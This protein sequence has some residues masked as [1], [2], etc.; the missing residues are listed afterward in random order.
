M[1]LEIKNAILGYRN[2]V[3]LQD[4]NIYLETGRTTC[5]IG[6]NGAGKTTLFKSILGVLPLLDGEILFDGKNIRTWKRRRL[7]RVVAYVPQVRSLSFAY[8]VF[9]VVLFGRTA[10]LS[11]F[12]SPAKKDRMIAEECLEKL[13]ISHLK[14]RIFT[15]LSG[16]EQ[17]MVIIARALAQKTSFLVMDE[18]T[19]GLDFGNQIQIINRVN[20]LKN[21][22]LGI[23]MATHSPDH[24]FMCNADVAIVHKN[25]IWRQGHC[26]RIIT[27]DVL[28]EIY[29]ISVK[30]HSVADRQPDSIRKVCVPQM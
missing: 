15:Q 9:D 19:S 16:G 18:P 25:G 26:N 11:A 6:R 1:T 23:L 14:N 13:H 5:V 4:V 7:A 27:E 28:K 3:V 12:S 8:T 20:E 24:A 17:Q 29:G 22:E 10:Y 21:D 2:K 30:I